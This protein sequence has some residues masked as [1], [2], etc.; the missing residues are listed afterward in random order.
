MT[1]WVEAEQESW[2]GNYTKQKVRV[3]ADSLAE[4]LE[5]IQEYIESVKDKTGFENASFNLDERTGL[6]PHY[7]NGLWTQIIY[8]IWRPSE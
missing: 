1:K 6:S 4:L 3:N 7:H 5:N 8:V 2:E